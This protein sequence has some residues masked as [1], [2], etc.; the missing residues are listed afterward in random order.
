MAENQKKHLKP[1]P[2]KYPGVYVS[3][4]LPS[5]AGSRPSHTHRQ[6]SG[7]KVSGCPRVEDIPGRA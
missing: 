4:T 2:K 6:D 3:E 7:E 1:R 5:G